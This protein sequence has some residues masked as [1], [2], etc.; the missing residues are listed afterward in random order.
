MQICSLESQLKEARQ[1]GASA[2]HTCKDAEKTLAEYQQ[3][4]SAEVEEQSRKFMHREKDLV[5]Q[6]SLLNKQLNETKR[7]DSS[8]SLAQ[9][10]LLTVQRQLHQTKVELADAEEQGHA[11]RMELKTA[12]KEVDALHN[13]VQVT[14]LFPF[15]CL[16]FACWL[17]GTFMLSECTRVA[18][19]RF[20][21]FAPCADCCTTNLQCLK[22]VVECRSCLNSCL[23][24]IRMR[25]RSSGV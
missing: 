20:S 3:R 12:H 18:F 16:E 6:I 17:S 11:S 13:Q 5:E 4:M 22:V 15:S 8:L 2:E 9:D 23:K 21:L 14:L 19:W 24:L 10:E 1:S 7:P 25:V